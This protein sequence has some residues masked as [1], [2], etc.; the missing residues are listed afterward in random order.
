MKTKPLDVVYFVSAYPNNDLRY[1]IR[2]VAENLEFNNLWIYGGKKSDIIPDH[3]EPRL[4]QRGA[5]K[6][7]KVRAMYREVCLNENI[8]EDFI[9]F[10]DDFFVLKPTDKI[11]PEYLGTFEDNYKAIERRFGNEPTS[12]TKLL[13]KTAHRLEYEGFTA[14]S[15]ELHKPFV[16]NRNKLLKILDE[17]GDEHCIRS[18]YANVYKIGGKKTTDVK[19][20]MPITVDLV[21]VMNNWQ[22][23]STSD[24][25][26]AYGHIGRYL[27]DRFSKKCR[28]E[29]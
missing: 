19:I 27:K 28:F 15:Y 20:R 4:N 6:W 9:M 2:S 16:F 22:L 7:S 26:F 23:V 3:Y 1:S 25:S 5:D 8:T 13:R 18:I 21:D 24:D 10:H 29:V 17:Y 12:Y 11:E 14:Y